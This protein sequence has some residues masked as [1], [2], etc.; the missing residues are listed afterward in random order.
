MQIRR[1]FVNPLVPIATNAPLS[2]LSPLLTSL[3]TIIYIFLA[4]CRPHSSAS[5]FLS[6]DFAAREALLT[7]AR[8]VLS[9]ARKVKAVIQ[10]ALA[11][12][13]RRPSRTS[14]ASSRASTAA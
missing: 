6:R 7:F 13:A 1:V 9:F 3:L 14:A 12:T 11:D 8:S 4:L 5:H 10:H 2:S